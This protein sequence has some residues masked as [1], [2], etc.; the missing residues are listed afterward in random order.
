MFLYHLTLLYSPNERSSRHASVL[1][2]FQ[3]VLLVLLLLLLLLIIIIIALML[4]YL[5]LE[6]QLLLLLPEPAGKTGRRGDV[7]VRD[8]HP[9]L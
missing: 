3:E 8:N 1:L 5:D 9:L 6:R 4:L 2:V 7:Q